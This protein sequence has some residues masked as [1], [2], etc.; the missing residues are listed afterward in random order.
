MGFTQGEPKNADNVG[1]CVGADAFILVVI[2]PKLTHVA[3][4]NRP[5][6]QG[7]STARQTRSRTSCQPP[8]PSPDWKIY[9]SDGYWDLQWTFEQRLPRRRDNPKMKSVNEHGYASGE[10]VL[11]ALAKL[12]AFLLIGFVQTKSYRRQFNSAQL[13]ITGSRCYDRAP[14]RLE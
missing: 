6:Q 11:S 13:A 3:F 4:L 9:C 2:Q 1:R 5:G 12:W 10:W 14:T 7:H 8:S